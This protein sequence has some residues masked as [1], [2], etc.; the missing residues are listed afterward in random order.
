MED[1]YCQTGLA[2]SAQRQYLVTA[3]TAKAV[4]SVLAANTQVR[5]GEEPMLPT[6]PF[7][8]MTPSKTLTANPPL[9]G[10]GSDGRFGSG[11]GGCSA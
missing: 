2:V 3:T 4:G 9:L 6:L 8:A 10:G 5:R 11:S 7:T 1:E